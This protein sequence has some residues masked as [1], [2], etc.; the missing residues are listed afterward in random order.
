MPDQ[1][2]FNKLVSTRVLILGGSSGIGYAVAEGAIESNVASLIIS[3]SSDSKVQDGISRL[4]AAYPSK[5]TQITGHTTQLNDS[6]N[7]EANIVALLEF[8]T[9][10][11][12]KLL[13][14]VVHTA[15]D[16]LKLSLIKDTNLKDVV[17]AGMVRYFSV[18][19]LAK[20]L[21]N[22][23]NP[24]AKSSLTVT[25]AIVAEKPNREWTVY[26]SYYAALF[27]LVKGAALELAPFRVNMVNLGVGGL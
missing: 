11:R 4:K 18:F 25:T 19:M 22:Y 9:E 10:G 2:K 27:G 17:Q 13:D 3:S 14:H 8:A 24:G 6:E 21:P 16:S 5:S 20:H 23:V 7:L 15:G 1:A 26:G 12:T